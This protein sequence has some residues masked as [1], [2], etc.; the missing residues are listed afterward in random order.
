MAAPQLEVD[1]GAVLRLVGAYALFACL[2]ILLSDQ[3]VLWMF[4]DPEQIATVSSIKGWLFVAVTSALLYGLM[5]R[6]L[7]RL[8]HSLQ[9][10]HTARALGARS[11]ELLSALVEGSADAIFAKD[12]EGRY[13]LLNQAASQALGRPVHAVL[14]QDDSSLLPPE[15]AR[16]QLEADRRMVAEKRVRN[17]EELRHTAQGER[18][19]QATRGPLCD[20]RGSVIGTYGISRDITEHKAMLVRLRASEEHLRQ[21][22]QE[23][24]NKV[25]A[26]ARQLQDLYDQ[27]PCGYC[28]LSPDGHVLQVNQTALTL[29][30]YA[31]TEFLG[32]PLQA[33]LSAESA[34]RY[35]A[36]V[37]QLQESGRLR[38]LELDFI[39]KGG[40]SLPV[41]LSAD[42]QRDAQGRPLVAR[43][44]LVD[45]R[46]RQAQTQRILDL[47]KFLHD[48][49]E[50]LPF[51]VLVLDLQGQVILQNQLFGQLL[52]YPKAL[53][54]QVPLRYTDV[55]RY[56]HQRG[57]YAGQDLQDVL[58][59]YE[60]MARQRQP[61]Q[62]ERSQANG[63]DLEVRGQPIGAEWTLL[64]FTDIS[65]H[66]AAER[67]LQSARQVAEAATRAKSEFLAN[68]SHEI[69]TPMNGILGL[70]YALQRMPLEPD[71]ARLAH[72]ISQTGN[73]LQS[74]LNDILDFSKIEADQLKLECTSMRL[75]EVLESVAALM[76]HASSQAPV[77]CAIVPPPLP[78]APLLGDP[79]R[80]GQVLCNLV[81]NALKFTAS[82]QVALR[83]SVLEQRAEGLQLEFSVS[84][85]GIGI[86]TE[87]LEEIFKPFSQA[88]A[89]TTRR[90]GGTGLGLAISR[91]LVARMGGQLQVRSQPG[92]GSTF[93]FAL[94]LPWA[95]HSTAV[96]APRAPHLLLAS[97]QALTREALRCTALGLGWSVELLGETRSEAM[98]EVVANSP[99]VL[100]LDCPAQG[101][102]AL[103]DCYDPRAL[104]LLQE[105]L[106]GGAADQ[107]DGTDADARQGPWLLALAPGAQ[108]PPLDGHTPPDAVLS[109]PVTAAALQEALQTALTRRGRLPAK[110]PILPGARLQGLRLLVVDD[111]DINREI[112]QLIFCGEGASVTLAG[113]GQEALDWLQAHPQEVDLVV[114]DV[115]MP[116]MD[117]MRATQLLRAMPA[118]AQL[119]V[120]ALTAGAYQANQDAALAAG[121]NAHLA[122]PM[123][124]EQAVA[125]ICQLTGHAA[126]APPP[127]Q[128]DASG[129]AQAAAAPTRPAQAPPGTALPAGE[130]PGLQW[131]RGLTI[132]RNASVYQQYL[133]KFARDYAGFA[134]DL[135]ELALP[136]RAALAHKLRGAAANLALEPL[137]QAAAT[138][139]QHLRQGRPAST[140]LPALQQQL[141]Q[142]VASI[143]LYAGSAPEP[144]MPASDAATAA[145]ANTNAPTLAADGTSAQLAT[146]LQQTLLALHSDAPDPVEPLLAAL[147]RQLEPG[148]T[149]PLVR[150]LENFDFR[151]AE[152]AVHTLAQALRIPLEPAP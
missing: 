9:Q 151:A 66:K 101:L 44:T 8:A 97:H 99:C 109:K 33:L 121:M 83:V 50:V 70:A 144:A 106:W 76:L 128:A 117:G 105:R 130:L 108:P 94:Q 61:R 68:M 114:M 45:N 122:K 133:R 85:T 138:L 39:C 32:Q 146:L 23:L 102:Q 111:S 54:A 47:N 90:F 136:Q 98:G 123:D 67:S 62:F 73:S 19:Y 145:A 42:L 140:A 87:Q 25:A 150:A 80:L 72:K 29:L 77:E 58:Q 132:W 7:R 81:G 30:G 48:V 96:Q 131:Q 92:Q 28:T 142:A 24:E 31:G 103:A 88:D 147:Q 53:L 63:V 129:Q 15:Q 110:P 59:L 89:S 20:A 40:P 49:L 91:S 113:D 134:H 86:G 75:D 84:D 149:V 46:E 79:P 139:E 152:A 17:T 143:A 6:Q 18:V 104:A 116:V 22:N 12:L 126:H 78:L 34:R 1:S 10:E 14:G 74:I 43:C 16:Q 60:S 135:M 107:A 51:G 112:A 35:Q 3:A 93:W 41:L 52:D 125:V 27:A 119:P 57:D 82:G 13:I 55:L 141:A 64:T 100:L 11:H 118:F 37:Q 26:R 120:V 4:R 21:L 69:R 2:W 95:P 65:A 38:D 71:A 137:A 115:Q 56:N 124:V 127:Q 148:Q 5:Q 36:Q